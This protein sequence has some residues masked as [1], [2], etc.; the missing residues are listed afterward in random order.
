MKMSPEAWGGAFSVFLAVLGALWKYMKSQAQISNKIDDFESKSNKDI[1]ELRTTVNVLS[2]EL[3]KVQGKT[4]GLSDE[5][6]TLTKQVSDLTH[7]VL[8]YEAEKKQSDAERETLAKKNGELAALVE[9]QD[10][11]IQ[12]SNKTIGEYDQRLKTQEI[13]HAAALHKAELEKI[14]LEGRVQGALA[15]VSMLRF[16]LPDIETKSIPSL[17]NNIE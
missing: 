1:D 13:D 9:K 4:I 11:I 7:T 14:E 12:A 15:V 5:N 6:K 3:I 2:G 16:Q 17:E 10:G 8:K